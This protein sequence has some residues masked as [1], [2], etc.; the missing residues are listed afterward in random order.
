MFIRNER[1]RQL[2]LLF[3]SLVLQ[4]YYCYYWG[5]SDMSCDVVV[6]VMVAHSLQCLSTTARELKVEA[7]IIL[8]GQVGY[9]L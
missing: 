9:E 3:L 8:L 5:R 1:L 6:Y 2:L 7:I 4:L